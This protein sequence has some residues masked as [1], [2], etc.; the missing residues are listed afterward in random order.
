MA[1]GSTTQK[2]GSTRSTGGSKNTGGARKSSQS[3]SGGS[4][5]RSGGAQQR[6]KPQQNRKTSASRKPQQSRR[7]PQRNQATLGS[8]LRGGWNLTA[9]GVG[10]L[11]R[12]VGRSRELEAEHRRDGAA[13]AL[14]ALAIVAAVGVWWEAAGPIGRW[15]A[16]AMRSVFGAGAMGLP[17]LLVIGAV[18]MM[19]SEPRPEVRPR[20]VIG[21]GLILLSVLGL[22]HL[23]S[24]NPTT[25]EGV[26]YA[27]GWLGRFSGGLLA[28][29]V[30]SWVAAPLLVLA[31]GYGALVFTGTP[32]RD[33]PYRLRNWGLPPEE[34]EAR[35]HQ[36]A[37]SGT[38][39]AVTAGDPANSRT[40]KPA[41]R[42]QSSDVTD[43]NSVTSGS[44]S[45][46]GTA[47]SGKSGVPA[48]KSEAA[49]V[50]AAQQGGENSN[51]PTMMVTRTVE[52]DYELPSLKLLT[53]GDA[54]KTRS[55]VNDDMIEAIS[56]VLEEFKLDAQVTGFVRGPTVTRYEVELGPGVKVEKITALTKN[57][58]YAAAT[59]NV[60]LLAPI[61]GKSAVGIE[62]PNSDRE[63]VRL[64]DVLSSGEA[65]KDSHP[66]VI[67][68][69]KDIEGQFVTANLTKMP[70]LLVAGST[71]SGKSSFVNSML[72]SLLA[73]A[74]P[75]E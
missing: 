67:G 11:A 31:L 71:G 5:S 65:A 25:L 14:I 39:T 18:A 73:R 60:R 37:Q 28:T 46:S 55:K 3:R 48:K 27:G 57:I 15:V 16:I 1:S 17:I 6:R 72:V 13:L 51:E 68:L 24:S 33:V 20:M 52:G 41:R 58:A 70:H 50:P 59:D 56:N 9:R 36:S 43:E 54:P 75:D 8:L 74:T 30:T 12:T 69:G 66:L 61:P 4:R 49:A 21:V 62:V 7:S 29:G 34:V 10:S 45:G 2:R 23:I 47:S 42:R 35:D 40:R 32:I 64:G 19:R 53:F 22:L 44:G 26:M 63:M 38:D